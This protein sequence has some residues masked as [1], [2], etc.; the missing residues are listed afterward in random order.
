MTG[1]RYELAS[2]METKGA[3]L[4]GEAAVS[5]CEA[6]NSLPASPVLCREG[7]CGDLGP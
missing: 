1:V 4:A 5:D 6:V 3:A 7:R 2:H